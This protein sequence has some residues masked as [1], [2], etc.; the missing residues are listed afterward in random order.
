MNP[1]NPIIFAAIMVAAGISAVPCGIIRPRA[2]LASPDDPN[3][4]PDEANIET[5]TVSRFTDYFAPYLSGVGSKVTISMYRNLQ[6]EQDFVC[7]VSIDAIVAPNLP[8]AK[9][10]EF[11]FRI[12]ILEFAAAFPESMNVMDVELYIGDGDRLLKAEKI[13]GIDIAKE[14]TITA[15]LS[16]FGGEQ[17]QKLMEYARLKFGE[18]QLTPIDPAFDEDNPESRGQY[19]ITTMKIDAS[20]YGMPFRRVLLRFKGRTESGYIPQKHLPKLWMVHGEQIRYTGG[21]KRDLPPELSVNRD[22]NPRRLEV[23]F[24]VPFAYRNAGAVSGNGEQ[25]STTNTGT[26]SPQPEKSQ[27]ET[28]V[29]SQQTINCRFD[30]IP[31]NAELGSRVDGLWNLV[32]NAYRENGTPITPDLQRRIE[33]FF[34]SRTPDYKLFDTSSGIKEA[35]VQNGIKVLITDVLQDGSQLPGSAKSVDY[36]LADGRAIPICRLGIGNLHVTSTEYFLKQIEPINETR[37]GVRARLENGIRVLDSIETWPADKKRFVIGMSEPRIFVVKDSQ[38]AFVDY[39]VYRDIFNEYYSEIRNT[40]RQNGENLKD[41]AWDAKVESL[42]AQIKNLVAGNYANLEEKF[43]K[44]G[45]VDPKLV[46]LVRER[47]SL[48]TEQVAAFGHVNGYALLDLAVKTH[49]RRAELTD[50]EA[51]RTESYVNE[52]YGLMQLWLKEGTTWKTMR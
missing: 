17:A 12:P 52:G 21:G 7:D 16:G 2:A 28:S 33:E 35:V 15:L 34:S 50:E 38:E 24:P 1:K 44:N 48:T 47:K 39:L 30:G 4:T 40:A 14:M 37:R 6:P 3:Q 23:T 36:L 10:S 8:A 29:S 11:D 9:Q 43:R 51:R 20:D 27:P 31:V 22:M 13:P 18:T 49:Q 32:N 5:A 26:V 45:Q 42:R 25:Q 46:N 19:D 41:P